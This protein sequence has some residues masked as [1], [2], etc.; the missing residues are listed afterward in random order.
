MH[1]K[2]IRFKLIKNNDTFEAIIDERLSFIENFK[3]LKN[4]Y[5][6][7]IEDINV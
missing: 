4:I 1:D 2:Y 6:L 5:N 3:L 7:C